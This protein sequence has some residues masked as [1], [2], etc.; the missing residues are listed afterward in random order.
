[1]EVFPVSF[2]NKFIADIG[3]DRSAEPLQFPVARNLN[4]VPAADVA[5]GIHEIG[6]TICEI[7]GEMKFPFAVEQEI[8]GS[9][10][11]IVL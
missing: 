11:R 1:M 3:V 4:I 10:C 8:I 9:V 2:R 6:G 7:F 5:V